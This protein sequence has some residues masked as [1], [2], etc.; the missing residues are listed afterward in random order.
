MSNESLTET[1]SAK[2]AAIA[3]GLGATSYQQSYYGVPIVLAMLTSSTKGERERGKRIVREWT[4][5]GLQRLKEDHHAA[6][7]ADFANRHEP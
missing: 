7:L 2:A 1:T 6:A 3:L 5:A 4:S